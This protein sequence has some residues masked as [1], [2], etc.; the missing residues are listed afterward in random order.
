MSLC[1]VDITTFFPLFYDLKQ[2]QE[3]KQRKQKERK[4]LYSLLKVVYYRKT[5]SKK[6]SN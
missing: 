1:R 6:E 5:V 4:V 2:I 3:K